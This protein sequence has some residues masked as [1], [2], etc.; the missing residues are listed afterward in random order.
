MSDVMNKNPGITRMQN[1][2]KTWN[3]RKE[4]AIRELT[5]NDIVLTERIKSDLGR[6]PHLL[7]AV[8]TFL[9]SKPA[10]KK[11]SLFAR[12]LTVDGIFTQGHLRP[13]SLFY[14]PCIHYVNALTQFG[15]IH[16][17]QETPPFMASR[18]LQQLPNQEVTCS[19]ITETKEQVS[20]TFQSGGM[21]FTIILDAH[22]HRVIQYENITSGI[23][24]IY[25]A[26][27]DQS[28]HIDLNYI[29]PGD[30]LQKVRKFLKEN[31]VLARTSHKE[32]EKLSMFLHKTNFYGKNRF[33]AITN[34][35]K[36]FE[37]DSISLPK[38]LMAHHEDD[39]LFL[40][41][42][43][44]HRE[45]KQKLE[46]MLFNINNYFDLKLSIEELER[47]E[48]T[49]EHH[50]IFKPKEIFLLEGDTVA[51]K[52][53]I[54]YGAY[55]IDSNWYLPSKIIL[56]CMHPFLRNYFELAVNHFE[57]PSLTP[58]KTAESKTNS[59]A[60]PA[61]NDNITNITTHCDRILCHY[62]HS[63][64]L[65]LPIQA[66][67]TQTLITTANVLPG[68]FKDKISKDP[69]FNCEE[70]AV[71]PTFYG[72][73]LPE[74]CARH[75]HMIWVRTSTGS[76][77]KKNYEWRGIVPF[78]EDGSLI[79][80]CQMHF[81]PGDDNTQ[82]P[83]K[84]Q[85]KIISPSPHIIRDITR[86]PA[87]QKLI[88]QYCSIVYCNKQK[89]IYTD[90]YT[91]YKALQNYDQSQFVRHY[92]FTCF[93]QTISLLGIRLKEPKDNIMPGYIHATK[94][95]SLQIK[96]TNTPN[97]KPI[98]FLFH[99]LINCRIIS[100]R[101]YE[102]DVLAILE[103]IKDTRQNEIL[104]KIFS[105]NKNKKKFMRAITETPVNDHAR[106]MEEI[107]KILSY[108]AATLQKSEKNLHLSQTITLSTFMAGFIAA[109][110]VFSIIEGLQV[111]ASLINPATPLW[112]A[113]LQACVKN[114]YC[115]LAAF[116]ILS[117]VIAAAIILHLAHKQQT[118]QSFYSTL[119]GMTNN[120]DSLGST[121][122]NQNKTISEHVKSALLNGPGDRTKKCL[123]AVY[124]YL[125]GI[126]D[127]DDINDIRMKNDAT[128]LLR[129]LLTSD[130]TWNLSLLL[131]H[132]KI[133]NNDKVN[134]SS[135]T[136]S[137]HEIMIQYKINKDRTVK[138]MISRA[139][140]D[141]IINTS[142]APTATS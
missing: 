112:T 103:Q 16:L 136:C 127:G 98:N 23:E 40:C 52:I 67:S 70:S 120:A 129:S 12:L 68:Y 142:T 137:T 108:G 53:A 105:T 138:K 122:Q 32:V 79:D 15:D 77:S 125:G 50:D 51:M 106:K 36:K 63:R 62:T 115:Y 42:D 95:H 71:N 1:P 4:E 47:H 83:V 86:R 121:T 26:L 54:Y 80:E 41:F 139:E 28:T 27:E 99:S 37:P 87:L 97:R 72:V 64:Q 91:I 119:I 55:Q 59:D 58:D 11:N 131:P 107:S 133:D 74:H 124:C 134:V 100:S 109:Y 60:E 38:G 18:I 45:R 81:T 76:A 29:E 21:T 2:K 25:R 123:T 39:T 73:N 17:K 65:A 94:A 75:A 128:L 48:V 135:V 10:T 92:V 118:K 20:I 22:F 116:C 89:I 113:A 101:E 6:D 61:D 130:K 3:D 33:F 88:Q 49:A 132:T 19:N 111:S 8:E 44:A 7:A 104:S 43:I 56:T 140:I 117:A 9:S 82:P 14:H 34:Y 69:K 13:F 35:E 114:T 66:E 90:N 102:Y 126:I 93:M 46:E 141:N 84:K 31:T 96:Y 110:A 30:T 57:I 24:T 5:L 78:N 85:Y